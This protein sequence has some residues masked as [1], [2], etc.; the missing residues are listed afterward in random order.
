MAPTQA[1]TQTQTAGLDRCPKNVIA[2]Q[3]DTGRYVSR[4]NGCS[5][6]AAYPDSVTVHIESPAGLPY[7]QWI[8]H[9]L[10][11]GKVALQC[12]DTKRFLA[13]CNDC[14]RNGAY[15]D[16]AFVHVKSHVGAPF[17]QWAVRVMPNGKV[18]FQA[19]TGR[20][21]ARCNGCVGSGSYPDAGFVH[22]TDP[23]EPWAQFNVQCV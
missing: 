20:Y 14:H 5:P 19:D 11:N 12:S 16:S 3:A 15:P 1:A 18:T 2:L 22:S 17:A 13:R 21:L 6:N 4:C 10:K 7:A 23:N 9:R 8:V